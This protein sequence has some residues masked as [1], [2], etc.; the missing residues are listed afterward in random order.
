MTEATPA[1]T[2]MGLLMGAQVSQAI[3]VAAAMG[4]AD[5]LYDGPRTSEELAA[6]TGA[7]TGSLYRLLRALASVGV[8][9]EDEQK[10]F[11]LTP[12]GELLRSDVP[13][14]LRGWAAFIGRPYFSAAWS[15][16]EHSVRTGENAFRHVHGT[17]VWSYRAE[18][19]EESEIF[20]RAMESLTASSNRAL[21]DAYDF[22]RFESVVD[23]GGGN[24]ALLSALLDH[25]PAMRGILFDQPHVVANARSKLDAA[26]VGD[27]CTVVGG[28]FFEEVPAGGDA[29]TMKSILHDWDDP[30][31]AAILRVCRS[32]LSEAARLLLIERIVGVVNEDP[33]TK[34]L[35]LNML[36][37]P[38]GRER[39]IEEW[40]ALLESTGYV[41]VGT[42][43][44]TSGLCVIEAR[45]S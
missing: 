3:H 29:Y 40:L 11:A 26:G 44:T 38:G 21:L 33:R 42:T 14:S 18:H 36:V 7:H 31:A 12:L 39:T 1:A 9:R 20:D 24:G 16:L 4:I 10:R 37:V 2:L 15:E 27:R 23:V 35:D 34:F 5:L 8:F 6:E 32:G 30:E 19:P 41:L 22:G 28:S 13:G 45:A 25:Y 17:D 43:A